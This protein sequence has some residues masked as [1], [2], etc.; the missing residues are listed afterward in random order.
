MHIEDTL[1]A[2][3]PALLPTPVSR[4]VVA[5]VS[6][7]PRRDGLPRAATV[8]SGLARFLEDLPL[9]GEILAP[10]PGRDRAIET[11]LALGQLASRV[12]TPRSRYVD[13]YV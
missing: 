11:Y 5:T 9:Q 4:G 8:R 1:A 6:T 13:F 10:P 7:T 3:L 2:H 12:G